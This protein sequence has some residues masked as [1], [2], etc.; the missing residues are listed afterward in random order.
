MSS[1]MC[2]V[3]QVVCCATFIIVPHQFWAQA[4]SAPEPKPQKPEV[5]QRLGRAQSVGGMANAGPHAAQYDSEHR[6]ITAGGF[7]KEGPIVFQI[8]LVRQV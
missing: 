5:H 7:V 1:A 6:P 2:R 4:V 8:L 3:R